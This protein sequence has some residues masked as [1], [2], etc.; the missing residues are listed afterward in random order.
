MKQMLWSWVVF[1]TV[2]DSIVESSVSVIITNI[3]IVVVVVTGF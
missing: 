3:I 2:S 1:V